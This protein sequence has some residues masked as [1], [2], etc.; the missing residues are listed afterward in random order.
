M[1]GVAA[2][3][4]SNVAVAHVVF[5]LWHVSHCAFVATCLAGLVWAFWV[6]KPPP[7][8]DEQFPADAGPAMLACSV[9]MP[10]VIGA[11]L[12]PAA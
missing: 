5:D 4:W 11:K 9:A 10:T 12:E 7:W 2:A 3:A 8:H 6:T 1:T